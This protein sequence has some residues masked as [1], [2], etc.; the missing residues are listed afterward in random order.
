[1][2]Y[3]V[4]LIRH[5]KTKGNIEKRYIGYRTNE[6][7]SDEGISE[8]KDCEQFYKEL[9]KDSIIVSGPMARC[10]ETSKVLFGQDKYLVNTGLT[11]MDFGIFENHNFLE[12][13]DFVEYKAWVDSG[14]ESLIPGGEDLEGF[15]KRS[16]EAFD[17][18]INSLGQKQ[19][20]TIVCHGGNIMAI[21]SNLTGKDYFDFHIN[22]GEAYQV[23]LTL[24]EG[25][26]NAISYNRIN[27]WG[28]PG[29]NNR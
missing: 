23:N 27:P 6:S 12:L 1:M 3:S 28:N 29:S 26:L 7:L 5:G 22:P 15:I 13:K 11:E 24:E 9:S 21:M 25:K 16:V 17:E 14:C 19:K 2:N 10:Q 4:L 8:L 20:G 18:I